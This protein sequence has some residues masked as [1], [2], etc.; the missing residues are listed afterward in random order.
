MSRKKKIKI[1]VGHSRK[2]KSQE[3]LT[4]SGPQ[5]NDIRNRSSRW[6]SLPAKN[7][8]KIKEEKKRGRSVA[9][10]FYKGLL[11][12]LVGVLGLVVIGS[13]LYWQLFAVQSTAAALVPNDALIYGQINIAGILFPDEQKN[14]PL[15]DL[16]KQHDTV[17]RK[18]TSFIDQQMEPLGVKFATDLKPFLGRN[19]YFSYFPASGDNDDENGEVVTTENWVF[20]VDLFDKPA[21]ENALR[22][23]GYRTEITRQDFQGEEIISINSQDGSLLVHCLFL[24]DYLIISQSQ[25]HLQAVI[26][27]NQQEYITLAQSTNLPNFNPLT[28]REK[29]LYLYL[30]PTQLSAHI[31][32]TNNMSVLWELMLADVQDALVTMEAK[33]GGLL[34]DITAQRQDSHTGQRISQK[35]I[36]YLPTDISGFITGNDFSGDLT[37]FKQDLTEKSPTVEFH[38]N[39]FQRNIEEKSRLN[40]QDDLLKYLDDEYLIALDHSDGQTNYDFVFQLKNGEQVKTQMAV[41]EEAVANY[42]GSVYPVTQEIILSDGSKAQELLPNKEAFQFADMDF[43]GMTVRSVTS[44]SLS[45]NIS[46]IILGD[47]LLASTSLESLKKLL[48]ASDSKTSGKLLVNKRHFS[49]SYGEA[50]SWRSENIFYFDVDDLTDYLKLNATQRSYLESFDTFLFSFSSQDKKML[51]RGFGYSKDSDH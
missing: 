49:L 51:W 44:E 16:A 12:V 11:A 20:I 35:L 27:T 31:P 8:V 23:I 3:D 38:L 34:L 36:N 13:L 1:T 46:Y 40:L 25:S 30:Q 37:E 42:L 32:S 48:I 7:V 2:K 41:V 17:I 9:Y 22:K 19:L 33:E 43:A 18:G 4:K 50:A 6:R 26:K 5:V 28:L 29:F 14:K 39:N 10:N 47:K 21:A 24:D 45:D 15:A